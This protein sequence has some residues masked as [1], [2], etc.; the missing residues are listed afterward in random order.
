[1]STACARSAYAGMEGGAQGRVRILIQAGRAGSA[2]Q[3]EVGNGDVGGDGVHVTCRI[4]LSAC[5]DCGLP[6]CLFWTFG[7]SVLKL[8][9]DNSYPNHVAQRALLLLGAQASL[10]MFVNGA[11]ALAW[12]AEGPATKRHVLL[13]S[14]QLLMPGWRHMGVRGNQALGGT[15]PS[16]LWAHGGLGQKKNG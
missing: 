12:A 8:A 11:T 5:S 4:A 2:R 1:M 3:G 14:R 9:F 6:C 15:V 13:G 7:S 10:K 16:M